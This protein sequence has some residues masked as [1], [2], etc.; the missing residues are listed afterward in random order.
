MATIERTLR[1]GAELCFRTFCDVGK[2]RHWVAGLR[3][4]KVVRSRP[5]G[6]ALEVLFEHGDTLSYSVLYDYDLAA[7]RVTW[8]P[9][10]LRRDAVHGW[11]E[12][13]DEGDG[14]RMSYAI[15]SAAGRVDRDEAE[16]TVAAFARW[17]ETTPRQL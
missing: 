17:V 8:T 15:D 9:G 11:A 2:L 3:R 13:H 10:V 5:D 14:C 16:R 7:R 12:F 1:A 6:L 4:A